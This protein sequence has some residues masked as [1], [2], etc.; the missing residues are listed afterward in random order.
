METEGEKRYMAFPN[1]SDGRFE[2]EAFLEVIVPERTRT[3]GWTDVDCAFEQQ[4]CSFVGV[5]AVLVEADMENVMIRHWRFDLE[6]HYEC[7]WGYCL[8]CHSR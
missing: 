5:Y 7:W 8:R 3:K 4:S 1:S 6:D 2:Y